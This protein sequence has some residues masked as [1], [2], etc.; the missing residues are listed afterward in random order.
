[1]QRSRAAA[2][3]IAFFVAAPGTLVGLVPWLITRWRLRTPLPGWGLLRVPGALMVVTGTVPV[4]AA[5]R[6][7]VRAGGTPLPVAPTEHLVVTGANGYVRNPMYVGLFG[8][9]LGQVLL[10]GNL[11][12]LAYAAATATAPVAFVHWYEEPTLLRRYGAEYE[13]YRRA[14]PGWWPR[15]HPW[16]PPAGGAA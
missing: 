13:A 12:L 10:F 7:F 9:L 1:M 15:R 11:R 8:A 3:S 14:V 5:F 16:S 4:V 2:I 6:E